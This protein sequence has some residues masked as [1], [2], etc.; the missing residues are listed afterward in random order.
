MFCFFR[1]T[2]IFIIAIPF[3]Y[4]SCRKAESPVS[5]SP[6]KAVNEWI[7][8][9]MRKNYLWYEDIPS[10]SS[11]DYNSA[12]ETFFTSLLSERE[13]EETGNIYSRIVKI[14]NPNSKTITNATDSY[15]FE[16]SLYGASLPSEN[17]NRLIYIGKVQYVLPD[18]PA[19][20]AGL[21]RGDFILSIDNQTINLDNYNL[22]YRGGQAVFKIGRY[23][24]S[25]QQIKETRT[26]TIPASRTVN[27]NPIYLCTTYETNVGKV[28]YLVYNHFSVGINSSHDTAYDNALREAILKLKSENINKLILDLRYNTGGALSTCILLA[29]MLVHENNYNDLFCIQT[30]NDLQSPNEI[31]YFFSPEYIQNGANLNLSELYVLTSNWTA[32]ASETLINCLRPYMNIVTIGKTTEGKNV[33][34]SYFYSEQFGYY[35]QPI[36]YKIRN[37]LQETGNPSGITPSFIAD[38]SFVDVKELGASNEL[39]LQT[40]LQII[41]GDFPV[42]KSGNLE[43]NSVSK[44]FQTHINSFLNHP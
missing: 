9:V 28:G 27:N 30:Y 24:E 43:N 17:E 6:N 29:S 12:P 35:L 25:T 26:V 11:L 8:T 5:D 14:E 1:N 44:L 34:S 2:L 7:E 42:V 13:K 21:L 41:E 33:G 40:A 22:L 19:A 38:D 31:R 10:S 18:S 36:T 32:S 37:S 39:L 4:W 3:L 15:G 16:F 23:D 20:D